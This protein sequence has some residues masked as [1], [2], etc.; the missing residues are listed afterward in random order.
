MDA[1]AHSSTLAVCVPK[2]IVNRRLDSG[3]CRP[4]FV[5]I[6]TSVEQPSVVNQFFLELRYF[7]AFGR[8]SWKGT[9][10]VKK[11]AKFRHFLAHRVV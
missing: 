5:E 2:K 10:E 4:K 8:E 1:R 3:V 11:Y 9:G 7:A 6:G